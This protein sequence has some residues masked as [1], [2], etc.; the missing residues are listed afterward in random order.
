[1]LPKLR[2]TGS[3]PACRSIK[4]KAAYWA[5]FLSKMENRSTLVKIFRIS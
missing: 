5:A 1:M 3:N 2:V 4:S